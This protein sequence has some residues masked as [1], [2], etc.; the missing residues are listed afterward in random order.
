LDDRLYD[1]V[2]VIVDRY[3]KLAL[4]L[5]TSKT[6]NGPQLARLLDEHVVCR[7]GIPS[8]I[9]SDRD[10][11]F[12]SHFWE[13]WTRVLGT[14]RR[15]STAYHPQTDGQTERTNQF[16]NKWLRDYFQG[17]EGL[18]SRELSRAQFSYNNLRHSTIGMSPFQA[19]YGYH[20]RMFAQ[21]FESKCVG[22]SERLEALQKIREGLE[23]SWSRA[24]KEQAK[25]YDKRH[26]PKEYQVGDTVGLST[27]N[28]KFQTHAKFTPRFIPV[29]I[30]ERIGNQ[31]YRVALPSKYSRMHDVF[32]VTLIEPW[33]ATRGLMPLPDLED[34]QEL[35]QVEDIE[36][37]KD[38]A[39]GRRY[40][41][42]WTGW[43]AEYNTWEPEAHLEEAQAV[44][45]K[46]WKRRRAH[47]KKNDSEKE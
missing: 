11:L 28:F 45:K 22:V 19:M 12:T 9:V 29:K 24:V 7:F 5:P 30:T 16:I 25:Y 23:E 39:S 46:Y 10:T 34:D 31:A 4:F 32:P 3:T 1:S 2:L 18:W 36:T 8:G 27:R 35:W 26:T 41:V 37:H 15:M 20:P 44:V 21:V 43:P 6:L 40:L 38:M 33:T 13:E 14:A 42:K 47:D 17:R